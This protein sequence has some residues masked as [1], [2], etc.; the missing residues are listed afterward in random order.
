M[1]EADFV[2]FCKALGRN[3]WIEQLAKRDAQGRVANLKEMED[4]L[5]RWA[6]RRT[7]KRVLSIFEEYRLP[8]GPI[9]SAED[10]AKDPQY[11]A[12]GMIP[13]IE[14]PDVGKVKVVGVVPRLTDTPGS[15]ETP[16]PTLGQHNKEIY[17]GLLGFS[18]DELASLTREGAL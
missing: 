11:L 6:S 17:C 16:P 12:R 15:I 3:D 8:C 13:E 1:T 9:L 18:E 5:R 7:L 4:Y 10:I 14:V 2:R